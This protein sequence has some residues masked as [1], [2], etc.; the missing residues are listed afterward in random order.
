MKSMYH[1]NIILV[2]KIGA[3]IKVPKKEGPKKWGLNRIFSF[4]TWDIYH[5]GYTLALIDVDGLEKH[6]ILKNSF[7]A[8][9]W[10]L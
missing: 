6:F 1:K 5:V 8:P 9:L 2:K 3:P 7:G 4:F 10:A